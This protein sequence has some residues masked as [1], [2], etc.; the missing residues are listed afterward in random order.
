MRSVREQRNNIKLK[1]Y[2]KHAREKPVVVFDYPFSRELIKDM[3][4]G[5]L[6][7]PND[8]DELYKKICLLLSENH[9]RKKLGANTY[10]YVKK[11]H[12]WDILARAGA[13]AYN[14]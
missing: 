6:V 12:N 2:L 10:D 9:L 3:Y 8:V 14:S 11:R 7:R 4:N 13:D 5:I 1:E